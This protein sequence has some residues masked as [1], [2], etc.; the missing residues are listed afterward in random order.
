[1]PEGGTKVYPRKMKSQRR[2]LKMKMNAQT[3]PFEDA[4]DELKTLQ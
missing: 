4:K 2:R 1:M 3:D